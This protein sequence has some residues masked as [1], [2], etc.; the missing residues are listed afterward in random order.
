V[1]F[2]FLHLYSNDSII[3]INPTH[4]TSFKPV[5]RNDRREMGTEINLIGDYSCHVKEDFE[6]VRRDLLTRN[7]QNDT[8]EPRDHSQPSES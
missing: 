5:I 4:V 7:P 6:D 1:T 8:Q 2:L 3:G